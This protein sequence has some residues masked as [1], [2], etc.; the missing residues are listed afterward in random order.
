MEKF[1][2]TIF[3]TNLAVFCDDKFL[4][5]LWD[6]GPKKLPPPHNKN[7]QTNKQKKKTHIVNQ[8]QIL[9]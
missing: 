6:Q 7:L 3:Q 5:F 8:F 4:D 9:N 2:T 1:Q